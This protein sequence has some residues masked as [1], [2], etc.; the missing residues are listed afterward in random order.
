MK[1]IN[2]LD[3]AID[4]QSDLVRELRRTEGCDIRADEAQNVLTYMEA[5]R[6]IA[7]K[8]KDL[9]RLLETK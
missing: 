8:Y 1:P 3:D 7:L 4:E 5:V 9:Q 6:V 2:D